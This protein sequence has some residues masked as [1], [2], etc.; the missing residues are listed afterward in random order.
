[1]LAKVSLTEHDGSSVAE[2]AI[3][4]SDIRRTRGGSAIGI[5]QHHR[6]V[7]DP[8]HES[9]CSHHHDALVLSSAASR[10]RRRQLLQEPTL[11]AMSSIAACTP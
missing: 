9:V 6:A 4:P 8:C 11:A 7:L 5:G 2:V 1:M 10:Q 3:S